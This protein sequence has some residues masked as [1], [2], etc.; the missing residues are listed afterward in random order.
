MRSRSFL[1]VI[2][3]AAC[4]GA[5]G[6]A[7]NRYMAM[8]EA[9]SSHTS[10]LEDLDEARHLFQSRPEAFGV[11]AGT[12][13][14]S[15]LKGLVQQS[16]SRNG[17]VLMYLTETERDAGEKI[18]ERNVVAR[19]VNVPHAKLVAFLAD[20]ENRGGGARVKEI[21]LKPALDHSDVYQEAEAVLALR[22]I[23]DGDSPKKD[24]AK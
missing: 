21:R 14:K 24:E 1:S 22:W 7:F 17:V 9:Q 12:A 13:A 23:N 5:G 3:F 18:K 16:S 8:D 15:D 20:L 6:F 2:V 19:A 4:I 11:N 10:R